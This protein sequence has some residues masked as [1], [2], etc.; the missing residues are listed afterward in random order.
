MKIVLFILLFFSF[1]MS[2][3][4]QK[5]HI[6][7][8]NQLTLRY[9]KDKESI[10][11]MFIDN[12]EAFR[13][14]ILQ[15]EKTGKEVVSSWDPANFF[16]PYAIVYDAKEEKFVASDITANVRLKVSTDSIFYSKD[17]LL[18]VAIVTIQE[19]NSED[20][21]M[22]VH[23]SQ[24]DAKGLLCCRKDIKERFSIYPFEIWS[25]FDYD[26]REDASRDLIYIYTHKLKGLGIPAGTVGG[27]NKYLGNVTDSSF[28]ES[29][30][31]N[32]S[33][34]GKYFF[35]YYLYLGEMGQYKYHSNVSE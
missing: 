31:F 26:N 33:K 29:A 17:S 28:F 34:E 4:S 30:I 21:Q 13:L 23:S 24:F 20:F 3:Q 12:V 11:S 32:K 7:T 27:R 8:G 6:Y 22:Q 9:M 19:Y 2:C 18:A 35:Q 10:A 16:S 25:I 5:E 15:E 1:S 14:A